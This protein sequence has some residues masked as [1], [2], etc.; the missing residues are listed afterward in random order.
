M[1][2]P[3]HQRAVGAEM[4]GFGTFRGRG[5]RWYRREVVVNA[6]GRLDMR[7]VMIASAYAAAGV[8]PR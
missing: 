5:C 2:S 3:L 8:P 6:G 4:E 1:K 7:N